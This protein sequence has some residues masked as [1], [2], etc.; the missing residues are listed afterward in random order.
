MKRYWKE[1]QGVSICVNYKCERVV[2]QYCYIEARIKLDIQYRQ[3][4]GAPPFWTNE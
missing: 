3:G 2:M 4:A 1:L